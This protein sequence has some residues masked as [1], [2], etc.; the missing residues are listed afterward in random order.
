MGWGFRDRLI[1]ILRRDILTVCTALGTK[2]MALLL[3]CPRLL[4]SVLRWTSS[5][6]LRKQDRYKPYG[7][8]SQISAPLVV[9]LA[10]TVSSLHV[11]MSL[12]SGVPTTFHLSVSSFDCVS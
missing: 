3:S 5:S 6:G 12:H 8:G 1:W 11:R 4:D 10:Q 2:I 7:Y 9:Y